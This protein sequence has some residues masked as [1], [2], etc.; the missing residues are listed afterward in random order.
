MPRNV[1][2]PHEHPSFCFI[3]SS[4]GSSYVTWCVDW[5]GYWWLWHDGNDDDD[6]D[7]DCNSILL[8][9]N[10]TCILHSKSTIMTMLQITLASGCVCWPSTTGKA[11]DCCCSYQPMWG[12]TRVL[13][14]TPDDWASSRG[15]VSESAI[16]RCCWIWAQRFCSCKTR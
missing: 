14:P 9:G 16:A 12:C 6:D 5:W 2:G 13:H 1:R 10:L 4:F 7:D 11:S 8:V 15:N 3:M